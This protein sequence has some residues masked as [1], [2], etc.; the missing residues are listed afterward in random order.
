MGAVK[1]LAIELECN[2]QDATELAARYD[3]PSMAYRFGMLEACRL[4]CE[5]QER[6][7]RADCTESPF[8]ALHQ[9]WNSVF[10]AVEYLRTVAYG[11]AD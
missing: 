6:L 4:I 1:D 2:M 8:M 9:T 3:D 5:E 10:D 7:T 11:S